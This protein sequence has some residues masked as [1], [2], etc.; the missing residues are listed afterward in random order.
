[1]IIMKLKG[2]L[3]NQL[4]QYALGR[5]LTYSNNVQLKLDTSWFKTS[6]LHPYSIRNFNIV[7]NIATEADLKALG[8]MEGRGLRT[9]LSKALEKRKLIHNPH[10]IDERLWAFDPEILK[11]SDNTYLEGYWASEKYF[12]EIAEVI[13]TE[14]TPRARLDKVNEDMA[15]E[16]ARA[17]SVSVHV[18]RG[19]YVTNPEINKVH[20][21]C[22]LKYYDKCISEMVRKVQDPHFYVFSDDV[23]WTKKNLIIEHPVTYVDHNNQEN[24]FKDLYLMSKCKHHIIANS[25]FSWWGAWLSTSKD[26]IVFATSRWLTP[27]RTDVQDI[28]PERWLRVDSQTGEYADSV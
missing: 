23:Q 25:S 2:G 24:D 8:I 20:G 17:S 26:H 14:L 11:V 16:M 18:R 19:D 13:R 22:S 27:G 9:T 5:R 15:S 6:K 10:R 1:M 21:T 4:F 7:E 28:I 12:S 3:G